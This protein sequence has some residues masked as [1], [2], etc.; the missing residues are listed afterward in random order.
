MRYLHLALTGAALLLPAAASA[1]E[2]ITYRYDAKG[3]LTTVS[4][5][6]TVNNGAVTTYAYDQAD[7]RT[8]HRAEGYVT[9]TPPPLPT[10]T[11]VI[12]VPLGGLRVIPIQ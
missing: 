12:V 5:A 6:G 1:A 7:N 3:R 4:H 9:S 2:T 8:L 10:P 11:R